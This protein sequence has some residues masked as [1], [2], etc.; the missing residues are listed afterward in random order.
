PELRDLVELRRTEPGADPRRLGARPLD[1]FR[2]EV[3]PEPLFGAAAQ[4]PELEHRE[5]AA[6]EP[7]PLAAVEERRAARRQHERRDYERHRQ[8]KEQEEPGEGDVERTE[9]R[10]RRSSILGLLRELHVASGER[11][12][13][14][15]SAVTLTSR[16]RRAISRHL[17]SRWAANLR[18]AR[19][20][21]GCRYRVKM[22]KA[23]PFFERPG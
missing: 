1:E 12:L 5:V 4:R 3:R 6:P 23:L 17:A 15:G 8:R 9:L 21:G 18:S 10:I 11:L 7:D 22:T 2:A 20:R 16:G 19:C 13:Q 14:Q